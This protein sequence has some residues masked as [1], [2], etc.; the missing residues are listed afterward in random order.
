MKNIPH[1][2]N[3]ISSR[4][5]YKIRG[6]PQDVLRLRGR[7][8]FHKNRDKERFSVR[9]DPVSADMTVVKLLLS[10]AAILRLNFAS[11]DVKGAYMQSRPI[12]RKLFFRPPKQI[13]SRSSVWKL[14]RLPHG[15]VEAERQWLC[16]RLKKSSSK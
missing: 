3:I 1:D 7:L 8:V 4:V 6:D 11:A 9:H 2:T 12:Q 13:S 16:V 15:I 14:T 5:V 10:S